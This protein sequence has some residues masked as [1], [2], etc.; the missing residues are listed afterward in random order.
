[1]DIREV[2]VHERATPSGV[3]GTCELVDATEER[4]ADPLR[5]LIYVHAGAA[6]ERRAGYSLQRD[7]GDKV[8]AEMYAEALFDPSTAKTMLTSAA[9]QA[10]ALMRDEQIWSWVSR[11]AKALLR[12]GRLTHRD[13]HEL[14]E[15]GR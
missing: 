13:I 8:Q 14:R 7:A 4:D 1:M 3:G 2:V 10:D 9:A 12:R 6:A 11:T 15:G 5:Y